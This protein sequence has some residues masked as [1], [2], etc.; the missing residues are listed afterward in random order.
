MADISQD[1]IQVV[2][3]PPPLPVQN[4]DPALEDVCAACGKKFELDIRCPRC[5]AVP[6]SEELVVLLFHA[7]VALQARVDSLE[8]FAKKDPWYIG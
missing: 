8:K 5:K 3:P 4:T 2:F 6:K 7:V 1:R